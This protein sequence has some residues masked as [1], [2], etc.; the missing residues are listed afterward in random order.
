MWVEGVAMKGRLDGKVAVITGGAQGIGGAAAETFAREG[1]A[2]L[3]ADILAGEG[4][5]TV[6]AIT[7]SGGTAAF[8]H[9]DVTDQVACRRVMADAV[10]RFGRLDTLVTCAGVFRGGYLSVDELDAATFRDVLE[11]NLTGTF[12]CVQAAAPHLRAAG[13]GVVLCL[14]SAAGVVGASGSFA[15][16]ASKGGVHGLAMTLMPHLAADGIRVHDVCPGGIATPLKLAAVAEQARLAGRSPEQ[17]LIAARQELGDPVGVAR[18]LAFLASDDAD[19]M[20]G[21]VFTR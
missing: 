14:G 15:Y 16:G 7:A 8:A 20:R 1:A 4:A 10:A 3:V 2:V 9:L 6:A 12:L 19:Y 18:V 21:A 5:R 11:I 13:G 17:A